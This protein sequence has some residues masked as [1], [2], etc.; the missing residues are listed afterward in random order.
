MY[1]KFLSMSNFFS[2]VTDAPSLKW[3]ISMKTSSKLFLRWST[4]IFSYNFKIL[5][6]RGCIH[7][8]A[9]ILSRESQLLDNPTQQDADETHINKIFPIVKLA[10]WM[11]VAY[12]Q[13]H[14]LV[15]AAV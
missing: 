10:N 6:R 3:L 14:A 13:F 8:N 15:H 4:H 11:P 7:L 1:D 2:L 5:H 9:D 12:V